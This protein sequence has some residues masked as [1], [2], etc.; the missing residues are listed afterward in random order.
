ME[1]MMRVTIQHR[2]ATTGIAQ[3]HKQT[4]IDCSV[5]LSDEERAIIKAH[6]L[7]QEG[8]SIRTSTPLPTQTSIAN[9]ALMRPIGILLMAIGVIWGLAGGGVGTGTLFIIGLALLLFSFFGGRKQEARLDSS[10]QEVTLKQLLSNPV[11]TIHA[12]NP[13]A[14]KGIDEELRDKLAALKN[15]IDASAT[16]KAKETFEL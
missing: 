3:N 11:F 13:A 16:L 7:Y 10:E 4:Y 2:E 5:V 6:D 15:Q 12:W 1:G 9:V 8:F 14:A